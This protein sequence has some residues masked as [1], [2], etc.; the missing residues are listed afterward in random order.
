M[1]VTKFA[2]LPPGFAGA[3][4]CTYFADSSLN[5]F[6]AGARGKEA[7]CRCRRQSCRPEPGS[8][9]PLEDSM[10]VHSSILAWISISWTEE[11]GRLWFIGLQRVRRD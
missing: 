8:A 4:L 3:T 10:A 9:D 5:G 7:A 2:F 1:C 6:P 11:P